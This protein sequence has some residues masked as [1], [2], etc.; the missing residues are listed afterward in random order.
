M[1]YVHTTPRSHNV[2]GETAGR[3][4]IRTLAV[5]LSLIPGTQVHFRGST[6]W[7]T[8]GEQSAVHAC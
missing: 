8:S 5:V 6:N 7:K 4:K 2:S 1:D 3:D